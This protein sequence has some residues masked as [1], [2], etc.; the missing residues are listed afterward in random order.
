MGETRPGLIHFR[1]QYWQWDGIQNDRGDYVL[2][3]VLRDG[4]GA[5]A[6]PDKARV[7][8]GREA[9]EQW[10]AIEN[11]RFKRMFSGR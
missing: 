10:E 7:V 4:I 6:P 9:D 8:T 3:C 11:E 1:G 2:S 5:I